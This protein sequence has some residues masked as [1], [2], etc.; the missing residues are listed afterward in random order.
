[1]G[2][3]SRQLKNGKRWYYSG[4]YKGEKYH[5]QAIYK[6]KKECAK[7]ERERLVQLEKE[8]T[9]P[10]DQTCLVELC[11][12]RLDYLETK[13]GK[14]Y[15]DNRRLF[16]K[17]IARWGAN[18]DARKVTRPMI[19]AY[20][21]DES[22][23]L[24]GSG[25]GNYSVNAEIRYL[26]ALF[27]FAIEEL[28]C[29]DKNPMHK[30]KFY[31]IDKTLKYIPPDEDIEKVAKLLMPHQLRLFRF[32]QETG[33]RISEALRTTGKDIDQKAGLLTL[34]TRKKRF[35][36]L[37]PRRIPLPKG[38]AGANGSKLFPEWSDHPRFLAKACKRAGVESFNWH[39]FRHRKASMMAAQ[40]VPI[41]Q[42]QAILG[43][44]SILVTQQYLQLLGYNL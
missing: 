21:L 16:R 18:I 40:G 44:E 17:I 13:S 2:Q 41:N 30:F 20:L 12:K 39:S 29:M 11:N 10:L 4:Q 25:R 37:T 34:W 7:A 24:A 27:A 5:S 35:G 42:I 38:L 6:T 31:P 22:K 8:I 36:D 26:K 32:C 28:E 23:R 15:K 3:Y 14:Y 19:H 1:M 33:C 9:N 43:H